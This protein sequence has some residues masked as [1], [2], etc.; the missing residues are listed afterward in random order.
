MFKNCLRYEY[1]IKNKTFDETVAIRK[2]EKF[3]AI[4]SMIVVQVKIGATRKRKKAAK[5]KANHLSKY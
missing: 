2:D 1:F 4:V 3:D 5:E